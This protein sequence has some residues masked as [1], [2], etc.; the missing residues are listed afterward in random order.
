MSAA[1]RRCGTSSVPISLGVFFLVLWVLAPIGYAADLFLDERFDSLDRWEPL[2]F[3]KISR[4]SS[5]T[6][7]PCETGS[8]L[9]MASDNSASG[10]VLKESF[11]VHR[12]PRLSWRWKV[13]NVYRKGDSGTKEGDDYP[14]RLYVLFIYEPEQA[15]LAKKLR[16]QM[17]KTV[18]GRYPPDSSISYIWDN[19]DSGQQFIVNAYASEARMIAVSAGSGEVN[20]WK[21]YSVDI[22]NDYRLAF[23]HDPPKTAKLAVMSD[24]DNTRES[25]RAW[26][27]HI[28]LEGPK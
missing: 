1:G 20:T 10:L 12:Y 6:I 19:R 3:A 11:D 8:C 5:Y 26:I 22:L 28:R 21:D 13:S 25:A 15:S 23:G 24:A 9:L 7:V 4:H 27:D 17:A 2:T 16:Y 18:Y 14:A